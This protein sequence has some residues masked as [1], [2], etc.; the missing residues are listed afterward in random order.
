MNKFFLIVFLGT[1][2]Y[3]DKVLLPESTV[4]VVNGTAISVDE[5][6]KEVGKLLPKAYF[7]STINDEKLKVLQE[8]A[9]DALIEKTLLY[10]YAVSKN[11]KT[12]KS[13]VDEV[14][15]NLAATYG[16]KEKLEEAIKQL[17]FTKETFREVV[18]KDE[19]LKKL[20][21]K[22][23]EYDISERELK[24]YYEKNSYKFKEPEKI[25][26]RL[27][28]VRNNPEDP[29]GRSKAKK[30]V[31]DAMAEIKKGTPFADVAAKYS[32]AM[33]RIKGG[34][35]GFLHRGRLEAAVEEVAFTMEI[36]QMSEIIEQDIGFFIVKVEDKALSNQLSFEEIKDGLRK[37]L[38]TKKEDERKAELLERLMQNSVIVKQ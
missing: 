34:D 30:R 24:D 20:Y 21:K 23:I 8:K 36:G 1:F 16:S 12:S 4:A 35:M 15:T 18:K 32:T 3:A 29:E 9:L 11:I 33:S 5:R 19:T 13:E 7:H 14:L 2:L 10:T 27:I 31:E 6:D 17:G 26:V 37:D 28:H 22:E 25:R 38:K